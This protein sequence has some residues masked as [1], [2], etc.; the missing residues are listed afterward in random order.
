MVTQ[1]QVSCIFCG[2]NV[3]REKLDLVKMSNW[4]IDWKVLQVRE[5]RAGPGRGHRIKGEGY[6]F[7]AIP[8]ESLSILEMIDDGGYV[9]LVGAI[10][11]RLTKIVK[12]YIDAGIINKEEL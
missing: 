3:I 1:E 2:K 9:D 11:N 7:P 4:S 8:E 5:I 6:G 12:A 10:K